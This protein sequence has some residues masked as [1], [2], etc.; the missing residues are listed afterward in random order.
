VKPFIESNF[1]KSMGLPTRA[2]LSKAGLDPE[3]FV[4]IELDWYDGSIRGADTELGR[5]L[6]ELEELGIARDTL[7]VF[8]S[9][10]GEEF[11]DHGGS[12]HEENVYGE[13]VNV[14]LVLRWPAALPPGR[15]VP[16]TVELLDLA[17]TLLDLAG[18][19]IPE[20]MQGESLEPLVRDSGERWRL[21]PAFSEWRRRTDQLSAPIVDAFSIIEGEWKLVRNVHRPE[22]VPEFELY[23][24][25][26]DRL[27]QKNVA[28]EHPEIV[29]RLAQQLEAWHQWALE[30][31]LP[32]DGEA[33]S[34]LSAEELQRLRSLGYVQ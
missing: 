31:K 11:F 26:T 29:E 25:S 34:E 2:E 19:E 9:D 32:S 24:H 7:L 20:R 28:S 3:E 14:P 4:K 1:M 30:K 27:D 12:F 10:H 8:L 6:E 21:R 23:H 5:I 22:G 18:L 13:L 15:V 33:E 16:E 17:P